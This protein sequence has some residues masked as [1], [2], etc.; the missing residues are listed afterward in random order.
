M[1][2]H[3]SPPAHPDERRHYVCVVDDDP[4]MREALRLV[5]ELGGYRVEE[6][7][8][9]QAALELLRRDPSCCL[10]LLDLMMP[11]MNGWQF[12]KAQQDSPELAAIPVV[13]LSAMRDVCRHAT[14]VGAV[15]CLSK[16]IAMDRL[17]A[18][19]SRRC[20]P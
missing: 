11:G 18:E 2:Q 8:E 15:A 19:V 16:P 3:Q 17:M 12:R 13:V 9:G 4:D 20:L 6:A 1:H 10:I 7:A 5:L 14:E